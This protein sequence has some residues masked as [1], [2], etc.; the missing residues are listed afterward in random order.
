MRW[1]LSLF[2]GLIIAWIIVFSVNNMKRVSYYQNDTIPGEIKGIDDSLVAVGLAQYP[3]VPSIMDSINKPVK[4]NVPRSS[5][6]AKIESSDGFAT[7]MPLPGVP[8]PMPGVTP[9]PATSA[10]GPSMSPVSSPSPKPLSPS[11][12]AV[13]PAPVPYP[14]TQTGSPFPSS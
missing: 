2:L 5:P 7:P 9:A 4:P 1:L 10:P 3:P 12:S 8:P 11:P 14:T 13:S 6:A